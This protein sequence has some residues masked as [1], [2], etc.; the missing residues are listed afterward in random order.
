MAEV[1]IIGNDIEVEREKVARIFDIRPTL[2]DL[3]KDAI[4]RANVTDEEIQAKIDE[5]YEKGYEEGEE[6]GTE[7]GRQEGYEQRESEE[8]TPD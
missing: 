5:A 1:R 6:H 8:K 2:F 3:L 7:K 4:E